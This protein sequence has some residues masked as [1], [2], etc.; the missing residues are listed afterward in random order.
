[1]VVCGA[2]AFLAALSYLMH[3][4]LK[5]HGNYEYYGQTPAVTLIFVAGALGF[6]APGFAAWYLYNNPVRRFSLR[7][8]LIIM[9]LVAVAAG[10]SAALVQISN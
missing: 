6:S 9:T 10:L 8:L 7:T 4:G 3:L 1:M 5:H 2:G